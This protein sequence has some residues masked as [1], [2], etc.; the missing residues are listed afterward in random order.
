MRGKDP[1][2]VSNQALVLHQHPRYLGYLYIHL[3]VTLLDRPL[4]YPK[5]SDDRIFNIHSYGVLRS[6]SDFPACGQ[7]LS[8]LPVGNPYRYVC[9]NTCGGNG[10]AWY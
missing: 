6:Y 4:S 2:L 3:D 9:I 5:V 1:L 8:G 10:K 7:G